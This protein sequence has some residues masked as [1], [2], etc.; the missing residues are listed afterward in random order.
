MCMA[1]EDARATSPTDLNKVVENKTAIMWGAFRS[2]VWFGRIALTG[3]DYCRQ[4]A[5]RLLY[6]EP[7]AYRR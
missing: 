4:R 3:C 2:S 5:I 6:A 7:H 1:G